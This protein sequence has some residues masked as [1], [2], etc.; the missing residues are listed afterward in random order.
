[1][2]PYFFYFD[3]LCFTVLL[4]NHSGLA[5]LLKRNHKGF[6]N[7]LNLPLYNGKTRFQTAKSL[8]WGWLSRTVAHKTPF[9]TRPS[10]WSPWAIALR[11]CHCNLRELASTRLP[12]SEII[13]KEI[14]GSL[15]ASRNITNLKLVGPIFQ[16][17]CACYDTGT[18]KSTWH[19]LIFSRLEAECL[20]W[21]IEGYFKDWFFTENKQT[22]QNKMSNS[23]G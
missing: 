5:L 23:R 17:P 13:H 21:S 4:I 9:R 6:P 11:L 3:L 22:K 1:M 20:S 16:V 7:T 8:F 19:H 15:I 18:W 10:Q 12:L 2:K 14:K